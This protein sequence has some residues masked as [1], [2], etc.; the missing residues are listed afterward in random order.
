MAERLVLTTFQRPGSRLRPV[1]FR[2]HRAD[3]PTLKPNTRTWDY[4]PE[5]GK[6]DACCKRCKPTF[7]TDRKLP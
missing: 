3:C 5:V 4:E 1:G 7:Y 6:P 2:L